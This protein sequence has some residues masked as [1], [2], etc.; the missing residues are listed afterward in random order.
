MFPAAW[1]RIV[2][3]YHVLNLDSAKDALYTPSGSV[4]RQDLTGKAGRSVGDPES[5]KRA[6]EPYSREERGRALL[7][8]GREPALAPAE[9]IDADGRVVAREPKMK[10][11]APHSYEARAG[12]R[13]R[14][15]HPPEWRHVPGGAD[16]VGGARVRNPALGGG[17]PV[18]SPAQAHL[19]PPAVAPQGQRHRPRPPRAGRG[20]HHGDRPARVRELPP[21]ASARRSGRRRPGR[22][23]RP[24]ASDLG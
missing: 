15:R 17:G 14:R 24:G 13:P 7:E 19:P 5:G 16:L 6:G 9:S 4:V 10:P 3:G 21:L 23:P 2:A 12:H 1:M 20:E 18:H 22:S 8:R 11:E